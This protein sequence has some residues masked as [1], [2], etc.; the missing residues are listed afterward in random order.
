MSIEERIAAV[1]EKHAGVWDRITQRD[2]CTCDGWNE[3]DF[4]DAFGYQTHA[5]HVAAMIVA[6]L[7]LT[8]EEGADF[9]IGGQAADFTF[10]GQTRYVTPRV[11][12][13]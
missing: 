7:G 8:E 6:E 10:G 2:L 9:T 3:N 5:S 4:D 11:D 1:I 13:A 12:D